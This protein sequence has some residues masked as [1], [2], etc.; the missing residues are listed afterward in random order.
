MRSIATGLMAIGILIHSTAATAAD[1][2]LA[3][4]SSKLRV[5]GKYGACRLN[6]EA[7][8]V[9]AG[10]PADF[11]R[12]ADAFSEK[13]QG[14]ETAAGP[15]VCPTE[16]D[17]VAIGT[18]ITA[19]TDAI[20]ILLAGGTLA[21][22]GNGVVD[23][24]DQCE[25]LDLAGQSCAGLG[26]AG[27]ALACTS[28]CA[29]DTSACEA[30]QF[31]ATGQTTSHGAGSDGDLQAG[32]TMAFV[33]NADGTITDTNTGLMWE[34]KVEFTAVV[35]G[36]DCTDETG[37]CANPHNADNGYSWTASGTA[38]DGTIATIFL[39][40][41]NNRCDR[42]TTVSCTVDADCTAPGG[43]CGFAGHRDWRLPN[44]KEL[45]SIVDFE[46]GFPG[47]TVRPAFHGANCGPACTDIADPAC[48][49]DA[50]QPYWSSTTF[51]NTPTLAWSIFTGEGFS[52]YDGKGNPMSVRAVRGG[53]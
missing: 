44:I 39:E 33:D 43:A 2:A 10:E 32:G 35:I 17:E 9:K 4:Q 31:P 42:D 52:Y 1:P 49:C 25:G 48:S 46:R 12:C 13:W 27:G 11:S 22:C 34:K 26:F 28:G 47:P 40:Q 37:K 38:F 24:S 18:R 50:G 8:A 5:A 36:V 21:E 14:S 41:L 15:L 29:F 19:H 51:H 6:A 3:C 45:T 20:A 16:G 53:S 7:K 23:G 30:P